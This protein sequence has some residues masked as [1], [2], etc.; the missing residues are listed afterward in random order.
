M[1]LLATT[2]AESAKPVATS[3]LSRREMKRRRDS[4]PGIAIAHSEVSET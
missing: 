2:M 3:I 4:H 1:L